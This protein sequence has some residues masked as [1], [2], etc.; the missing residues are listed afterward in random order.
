MGNSHPECAF[1][2]SIIYSF[3]NYAQSGESYFYTYS[4]LKKIHKD[5]K[6]IKNVFLEF[7]ETV[8][9]KRADEWIWGGKQSQR[10]S[11]LFPFIEFADQKLLAKNNWQVY[12]DFLTIA[13]KDNLIN[14][15]QNSYNY[16]SNMGGY[17][18]LS[19]SKMDS[20]KGLLSPNSVVCDSAF[21]NI[22]ICNISYLKKIVQ[23][24]KSEKI[25]LYFTRTPL[26]PNYSGY[27]YDRV[28]KKIKNE[29]FADIEFLDFSKFKLSET[30]FFDSGHLNYQ[31]SKKFSVWFNNLFKKGLMTQNNKQKFIDENILF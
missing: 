8:L 12:V 20:K 16:S 1:N 13:T 17:L 10:Y 31:G 19:G 29:E 18:N 26:H 14:L 30:E 27:C 9:E 5:C 24:C 6:L 28:L 7:D 11:N 22:S 15:F 2:D 25:N 21:T 23:Y 3:A 4:K